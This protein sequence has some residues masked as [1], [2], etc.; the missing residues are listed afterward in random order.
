[1]KDFISAYNSCISK[2][3]E[4]TAN[5]ADLHGETTLISFK[6]T[7]RNYSTSSNTTNGG[8]YKLLSEIGITTAAVDANNLST[9][10]TTLELDEDKFLK[11]LEED[12]NSVKAILAGETS[13]L[14]MMENSVEQ[15]LKASVGFF[16]VKTATLDS[17]ISKMKSK[18]TKQQTNITNYQK[19]LEDKFSKMELAISKMNQNYSSFLT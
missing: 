3:D 2:I 16:D 19:Q 9:D 7:L 13:I 12:P 1:M 8:A 5:G 11:A 4:V 14:S 15:S 6:N 18:I 17:D 10:I